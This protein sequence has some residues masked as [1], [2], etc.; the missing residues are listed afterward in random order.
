MDKNKKYVINGKFLA[1]R[2]QGIVRYAREITKALDKSIGNDIEITLLAPKDAKDI[3]ELSKIRFEIIG[4]HTG[5]IWEQTDLRKYIRKHKDVT[6]INF[7]NICPLFVQPGI[8]TIH[9]I[10]YKVNP[11]DYRTFRNKLSR[12]WHIFQYWYVARHEKVIVTVSNFSKGEIEKYYPKAKGKVRI[13]PSAWQHVMEYKESID[14]QERYP[15][16]EP[17]K[18]FFS[19][20]TLSRNKNG[21]WLIENARYNPDC[22]YAIAGKYYE[23]DKFNI[24]ENVHI[25]GFISDE[26]ACGLIKNCKAFIH[27]SLYEGFGFPPLEALALGAE[28]I[29]SN[30]TALPEVLG[31]SVHYIEP[32][33]AKVRLED[34]LNTQIGKSKTAL[35]KYSFLKSANLLRELLNSFEAV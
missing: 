30:A 24:P 15:F 20:S 7:C 21:K 4:K 23:T 5:M 16:L 19:L 12:Y 3:P 8:T 10:M 22:V 13:I 31:D 6:C 14:W 29:A 26:D 27:P 25:L 33:E 35:G 17:K 28:V 1:D 9:D 11:Q 18:Y 32:N 34:V 2:M